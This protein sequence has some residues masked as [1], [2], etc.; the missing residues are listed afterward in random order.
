MAPYHAQIVTTGITVQP[1]VAFYLGQLDHV[2]GNLDAADAWFTEAMEIHQRMESPLLVAH[3]Q[4]AWAALL[5]DRNRDDDRARARD[6]AEHALAT[7]TT[8]G[9]GYI[10]RD[11]R[12][13][14]EQLA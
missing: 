11:A 5:A 8:G 14:L 1:A 9:Y 10:E 6:M 4:A 2:L 12:A 7:A 3:T 13:V